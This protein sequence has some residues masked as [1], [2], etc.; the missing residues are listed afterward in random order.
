[1]KNT[2][3]YD[4]GWTPSICEEILEELQ[5]MAPNVC[6]K[7]TIIRLTAAAEERSQRAVTKNAMP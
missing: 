2:S 1:M 5:R 7:L 4:R 3:Y 6:P